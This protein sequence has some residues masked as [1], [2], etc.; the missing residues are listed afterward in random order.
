MKVLVTGATGLVGKEVGKLLVEKGHQVFVITRDLQ[1]AEKEMPFPFTGIRGDLSKGPISDPKLSEVQG[2]IH[3]MGESVVGRWSSQKKNKILDSRI[4]GT[5][6]LLQTLKS[7]SAKV[8]ISASAIGYYGDGADRDLDETS[9][10]GEGFLVEVCQQ[11]EKEVAVFSSAE[12]TR[13]CSLRIGIVLKLDGGALAQMVP[14]AQFGLAGPLASGKQWTSWIHI[15][16]LCALFLEALENSKYDGVINAVGPSPVTNQEFTES[17]CRQLHKPLGPAV[18]SLALKIL[19]GEF[20]RVVIQSQK[21]WPKKALELGF[22]FKTIDQALEN[23]CQV[24]KDGNKVYITEQYLPAA[25]EKVFPFFADAYNLEKITPPLLQFKVEKVSTPEIQTGSLIDYRL[26]I[27]GIPVRWRTR[28]EEWAPPIHFVD[29]QLKG[30]YTQWH[31]THQFKKLGAGT[32]MT[33]T[34]KYRLPLGLAGTLAA[35]WYVK[36][37]VRKIFE[38]RKKIVGGLAF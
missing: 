21:V 20:S 31:H 30:P 17:L 11:W 1:K 37:D 36:S 28:I 33:D 26:K 12:N 22:K 5:R 14:P 29:T 34:V 18:P 23:I 15:D 3:L 6:H 27:R 10:V 13:S 25:P 16:D 2:V 19:Y 4:L 35:G 7:T 38:Y 8:L 9:A 24:I 32:L